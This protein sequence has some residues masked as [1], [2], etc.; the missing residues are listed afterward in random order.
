MSSLKKKLIGYAAVIVMTA[1]GTARLG[2]SDYTYT[3]GC[4]YQECRTAPSLAPG[5]ALGAIALAAIIAIAVQNANNDHSH[6]H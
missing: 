1:T 5:I 3:G 6:C 4:C 2:A